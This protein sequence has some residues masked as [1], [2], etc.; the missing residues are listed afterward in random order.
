MVAMVK[1]PVVS[2]GRAYRRLDGDP[3]VEERRAAQPKA[4]S[5]SGGRR[6]RT[7]LSREE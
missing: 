2:S 5:V 4:R 1:S 7:C 6:G 3:K